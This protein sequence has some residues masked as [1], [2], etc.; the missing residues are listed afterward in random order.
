MVIKMNKLKQKYGIIFG[1]IVITMLMV[2]NATVLSQ[3]T[4]G[5]AESELVSEVND[6]GPMV[7]LATDVILTISDVPE[8]EKAINM[9]DD[10]EKQA[11]QK[12]ITYIKNDGQINMDELENILGFIVPRMV[13]SG[14]LDGFPR[15][16]PYGTWLPL[17]SMGL[18]DGDVKVHRS[19]FYTTTYTAP[20]IR[21]VS[22]VF[23]IGV[24]WWTDPF[25][26][27][28]YM[29]GWAFGLNIGTSNIQS[30][31]LDDQQQAIVTS[32]LTTSTSTPS[33][34]DVSSTTNI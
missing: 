2:S 1:A 32:S 6:I 18:L 16:L 20:P 19:L 5:M 31:T 9:L 21:S 26:C 4:S 22:F 28:Y 27:S 34:T 12:V 8:L 29:N 30:Q 15:F 33:T 24:Y 11:M 25:H 23:F 14:E 3:E 7:Y 10:N 13:L 17:C